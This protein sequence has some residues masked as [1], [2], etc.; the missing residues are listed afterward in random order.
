MDKREIE[1]F[2]L[3]KA[4]NLDTLCFKRCLGEPGPTLTAEQ[5]GCLRTCSKKYVAGM[6]LLR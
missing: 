6:D 3:K 2:W 1:D 5:E 4:Y